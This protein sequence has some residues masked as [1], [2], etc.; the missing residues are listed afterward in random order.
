MLIISIP[1]CNSRSLTTWNITT[2]YTQCSFWQLN[3]I[4]RMPVVWPFVENYGS[5]CVCRR[6]TKFDDH[7]IQVFDIYHRNLINCSPVWKNKPMYV[8]KCSLSILLYIHVFTVY[9]FI[10]KYLFVYVNTRIFYT[11]YNKIRKKIITSTQN[12]FNCT[13]VY[14]SNE[15]STIFIL[16]NARG[17]DAHHERAR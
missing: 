11:L 6:W 2:H 5:F 8:N 16:I 12:I 3:L 17:Q 4:A 10:D 14:R 13:A 7:L 9:S 1:R 15:I